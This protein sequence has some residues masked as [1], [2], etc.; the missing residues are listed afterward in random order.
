MAS[1]HSKDTKPEVIFRKALYAAGF[2]YR[3]HYDIP[4]KPDIVFLA[5]R[6]AVFVDGDFWHGYNWLQKGIIPSQRYWQD[7]I[8]KNVQRDKKQDSALQE[9][10]WTVLRIW[11]HEVLGSLPDCIE[12]VKRC[13]AFYTT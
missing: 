2:R 12:R 3:I 5:A 11:E 6:L 8:R 13:V 10:G 9:R 7:K 4:G 1:I